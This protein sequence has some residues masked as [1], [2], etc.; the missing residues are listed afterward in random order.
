ML[1]AHIVAGDAAF[2]V[3]RDQIGG[4]I[5]LLVDVLGAPSR[6]ASFPACGGHVVVLP[7]CAVPP[8]ISQTDAWN[9]E[10]PFLLELPLRCARACPAAGYDY[11]WPFLRFR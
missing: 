5:P 8:V 9:A 10:D 11:A 6:G 4:H 7:V 2:N 3:R 1:H